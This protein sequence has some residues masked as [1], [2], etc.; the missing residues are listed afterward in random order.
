MKVS[1]GRPNFE[2]MLTMHC[3]LFVEIE[4]VIFKSTKHALFF[5]LGSSLDQSFCNVPQSNQIEPQSISLD[6][7]QFQMNANPFHRTPCLLLLETKPETPTPNFGISSH[8][9]CIVMTS[10]S[11][12]NGVIYESFRHNSV[13]RCVF[14]D[15][16]ADIY[17]DHM[18]RGQDKSENDPTLFHNAPPERE[19]YMIWVQT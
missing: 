11:P 17:H 1:L 10:E 2:W 8:W 18:H 6:P 12:Q 7:N 14:L 15:G 9:G 16:G 3:L 13:L 19:N 4:K 5:N